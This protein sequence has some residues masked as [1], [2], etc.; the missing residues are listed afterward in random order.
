MEAPPLADDTANP[1]KPPRNPTWGR[2]E[3]IL[4]LD[5][6]MINPASP[7]GKTSPEVIAL[8]KLLN[9]MSPAVGAAKFR[10]P[11]GVYMKMMNFR[12]FD[13]DFQHRGKVGLVR[14]GKDE[15]QVWKDFAQD[16]DHLRRLAAAIEKAVDD[17]QPLAPT[18][19][20]DDEGIEAPEGRYLTI[21]HRRRERNQRLVAKRIHPAEAA[22]RYD[23]P[24]AGF[25]R[26]D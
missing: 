16:R 21:V 20:E 9:R 26:R 23:R 19:W 4:A 8:S 2:D 10:N 17:W 18:P 25:L 24:S 6:Y 13:P 1:S 5:L 14:G 12:R 3:L 15:E 7:P 22:G 11:N